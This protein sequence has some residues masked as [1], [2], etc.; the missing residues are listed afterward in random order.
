MVRYDDDNGNDN[1]DSS[2]HD[3]GNNELSRK[4]KSMDLVN[5]DLDA[6]ESGNVGT[7][8][9][10]AAV[11]SNLADGSNSSSSSSGGSGW[12][13]G[14]SSSSGAASGWRADCGCCEGGEHMDDGQGGDALAQARK[15]QLEAADGFTSLSDAELRD[16]AGKSAKPRPSTR[17]FDLAKILG[18]NRS[19][20]TSNNV[21][22]AAG[23]S[24]GEN[25]TS[26]PGAAA[27]DP[28]FTAKL[29]ASTDAEA[30]AELA[31]VINKDD[32]EKMEIL[33]QFNLGFMV[34]RLNQDLFI[35]DQ[36]ATDEKFNFERLQR[37]TKMKSQRLF[38]PKR[39]ELTAVSEEVVIDNL[40]IF[41][42]NGFDFDVQL[43]EP[44]TKRVRMSQIPLSKGTVFDASDVDELIF[45]LSEKPGVM[46][47]PSRLRS[48][49]AMRACRSSVMIGTALDKPR[50]RTLVDHMGTME[51]PWNCPHGRPTMRHVFDLRNMPKDP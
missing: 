22:A 36:H 13:G 25:A 49:F 4:R 29:G 46:C 33:G 32:F 23:A 5:A 19:G 26:T 6:E 42:R 16:L 17:S 44:P 8:L 12:R 7:D 1:D 50:M 27:V 9:E 10:G 21:S 37:T 38:V 45:M 14:S 39:L 35:I 51:Q 2:S 30:E 11:A 18:T 15:A 40:E 31:R 34:V 48:M 24:Q 43:S 20:A 41:R 47:R 3:D 28:Q